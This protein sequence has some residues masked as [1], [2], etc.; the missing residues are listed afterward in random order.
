MENPFIVEPYLS[1]ELFCD[2]EA[3]ITQLLSNYKNGFNTSLIADRRMGKTGLIRCFF[4]EIRH[5]KLPARH[6]NSG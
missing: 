5:K 4:D 6:R 3:E 1:K 2:R